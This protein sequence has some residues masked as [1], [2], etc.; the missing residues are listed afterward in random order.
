MTGLLVAA[1]L[2][3]ISLAFTRDLP[4]ADLRRREEELESATT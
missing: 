3:L 2:V 4:S 1:L